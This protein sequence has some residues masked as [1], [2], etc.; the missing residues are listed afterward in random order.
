MTDTAFDRKPDAA[1]LPIR[2]V[3]TDDLERSRGTV[4][5]RLLLA[6]PHIVVVTLYGIAAAAVAVILW[7]ALVIEGKAPRSLQS[8]VASYLRYSVQV[9]AYIHVAAS[10]YPAFGGDRAYPVD[11]EIDVAQRQSRG[12]VAARLLLVVPALIL[13]GALGG[14]AW[15]G[16]FSFASSSSADFGGGWSTRTNFVGVASSA[17]VLA[18]FSSVVRGRTPRGLRDLIVYCIGYTAQV[19]GYFLLVTDRYPT[20][21][22]QRI[23][24]EAELPTHPVRL[25][26]SDSL[27]R[28][29]LTVFFRLLLAIPHFIWLFLWS[30][31]AIII[32]V[33]AWII[34]LIIGR[35]PA[36]LHRFLAAWVRYGTHLGAFVTLVGGPFPGFTG[37]AGSYPVDL[38]IDPPAAQRRLVTLFRGLLAI[39]ALVL[40]SAFS[41]VL[42]VIAVL[43]WWAS[44]V[45]REMPEGLRNL[46][47]VALRYSGQVNA[48]LFLLTDRYPYSAPV[49]SEPPRDEQLTLDLEGQ[50][51]MFPE[52]EQ[53]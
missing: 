42:W 17:L 29:R 7:L 3:V 6:I 39:P 45:K 10:P 34:A 37:T 26:L 1:R 51:P 20:S 49:V 48:Y 38:V 25:D 27:E 35:V 21:D 11:L 41:L 36:P 4:F 16:D 32:V 50:T 18:W 52:A 8:F 23:I 40:A 33:P 5:F 22:P 13:A 44:I 2:L 28:S 12:R 43:G 30:V 19:A 47:S 9:S 31:L 15:F 14:G 46:G 24:P 53:A